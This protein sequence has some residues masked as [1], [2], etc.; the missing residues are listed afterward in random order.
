M[1]ANR[2][3]Y[4][5]AAALLLAGGGCHSLSRSTPA[6]PAPN[7][8]AVVK[9]YWPNGKLRVQHE[10]LRQPDGTLVD[11]GGYATWF[12]N[13]AKEYEATYVDGRLEGVATRWHRNG[14]KASEQYYANGLRNGPRYMWDQNGLL[15]KEEHFVDDKPDG[16]WTTWDKD[17]R[18]EARQ[19]WDKGAPKSQ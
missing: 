2:L 15:R 8:V 4:V 1:T 10:F 18:I 13:G 14:V 17:G 19:V 7:K 16:V 12:D 5:P 6:R 3:V 9:E 11:N